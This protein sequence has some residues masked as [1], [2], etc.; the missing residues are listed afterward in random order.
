[1]RKFVVLPD[2]R[3]EEVKPLSVADCVVPDSE[4][5]PI[6]F[7]K[8]SGF[9]PAQHNYEDLRL[10]NNSH[11][12]ALMRTFS[13][14]FYND[15]TSIMFA[16][17]NPK[18][19][20]LRYAEMR[21]SGESHSMAEMLA[22]RS[23]PGVKTDAVFNEGKFSGDTG[24]I[25]PQQLWLQ[26][27]A[28]ASGVSTTGKWYCSG[29]ASFPGD[30][31]AWVGDRGDVLRIAREKNMTVHGYVEHS[32]HETDGGGDV[33]I[34]DSLINDEVDDILESCPYADP[35]AVREQVFATRTGAVDTNPLLCED[36]FTTD[37]P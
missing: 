2:G 15:T 34:A 25:G 36:H 30:P 28:K 12:F 13:L 3:Y 31:T 18:E 37:I 23:F 9:E 20:S 19:V 26:E 10:S 11:E 16:L 24:K 33:E 1:M 7:P 35:E 27:Q 5:T 32:A 17:R 14:H 8:V 29:L 22:T 4:Y 6:E 21:L